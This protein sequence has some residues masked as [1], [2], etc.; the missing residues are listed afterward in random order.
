M[1]AI[2]IIIISC[3]PPK[4]PQR[5]P[6]PGPQ[7][8]CPRPN[9]FFSHPMPL[10]SC[11]LSC[12]FG[13]WPHRAAALRVCLDVRLARPCFTALPTVARGVAAVCPVHAGCPYTPPPPA[14]C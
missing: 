5:L 13:A 8:V 7:N 11:P 9:L 2:L 1:H 6:A 12:R 4:I 3:T 14:A 10:G